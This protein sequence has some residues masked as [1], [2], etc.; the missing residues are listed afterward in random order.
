MKFF[1]RRDEKGRL[2]RAFGMASGSLCCLYGRRRCGKSRLLR[3]TIPRRHAVY[4]VADQMEPALQRR[5]LALDIASV[6][7]GFDRVAYP[8]WSALLDRWR[9]DAP[10]GACLIL[11][12]FPYLVLSSPELPSI[13]QRVVDAA[14]G[15]PLHIAICGSSQRMMQG[16]VL[17]PSAPLYGR[18]REIL[19]ISPLEF[20]WIAKAFPH[21]SPQEA[22]E[23]FSVWG[24]VPRYWELATDFET[25]DDAIQQLVLA[26]QGVL[27]N[28]PRHLLMDDLGDIV[29]ASS[30]LALIGQGCHRLSEIAARIMKPATSMTRP[31]ARLQ[32]LDLIVREI[33][34]G[35]DERSGKTSLYRLADPFLAFWFRFVQPNR[36]LLESAPVAATHRKMRTAFPQHAAWVWETLARRS[37]P[38]L[39]MAGQE[40]GVARRWWGGDAHGQPMEIDVM[41]ESSDGKVLLVGEAKLQADAAEIDDLRNQL[42]DKAARLPFANRYRSVETV[43]FSAS[44]RHHKAASGVVTLP[45]I[46]RSLV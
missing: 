29:Q 17:A 36:S 1:N 26:P 2:T 37:V 5:R 23:H 25:L 20:G 46:L 45:D 34:F 15:S 32:E 10:A 31:L 33:P 38:R 4:H 19:K 18:A 9:K 8:D 35:A 13:L 21:A 43:V 41:A 27:H 42:R 28:E 24:G 30:I 11:D 22:L 40:W 12:E 16:L 39:R 44:G 6:I 7:P 14:A 3:E